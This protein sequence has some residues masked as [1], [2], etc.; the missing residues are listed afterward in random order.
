MPEEV[1]F[2]RQHNARFVEQ[3]ATH[4]IIS[5]FDNGY[6]WTEE[7][8]RDRSR[9]LVL[10]LQTK[11]MKAELVRKVDHPLNIITGSRGNN[12]L[13][14]AGNFFVC[15][16]DHTRLSEH[17]PDG[18]LLMYTH[19]KPDIDTY[20]AY[21]FPWVG[22]PK[23]P[24]NVYAAAFIAG[25]D[26]I[27]TITYVSWNGATEVASW[28]LHESDAEG[29][30]LKRLKKVPRR[31]FETRIMYQGYAKYV[32][33]EALDHENQAIGRSKV[34][35]TIAPVEEEETQ[36]SWVFSSLTNPIST[37]I[38]GFVACAVICAVMWCVMGSGRQIWWR[39]RG[40]K[41][42]AAETEDRE[43]LFG[44]DEEDEDAVELRDKVHR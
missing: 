38:A 12:Q 25:T 26:R 15:W 34:V 29:S 8:T 16:V 39:S 33:V 40:A 10:A 32:V 1:Q 4:T 42:E 28:T 6:G 35:Q 13:L 9:G 22:H 19:L 18:K 3:S 5:L 44:D 31:G 41:Y 17:S 20:R 21:K 43:V 30:E 37:F 7:T 11:Q 2:S 27:T 24:P 23:Q 14:P 36:E